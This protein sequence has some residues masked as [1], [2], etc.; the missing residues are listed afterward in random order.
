MEILWKM[1]MV[2]EPC[3]YD[4]GG[5][6][7]MQ[8]LWRQC[9]RPPR[10][11]VRVHHGRGDPCVPTTWLFAACSA[12][13]WVCVGT[14]TVPH[15]SYVA[16]VFE[17]RQTWSPPDLPTLNGDPSLHPHGSCY[18]VSQGWIE[19][20]SVDELFETARHYP[21]MLVFD[22]ISNACHARSIGV[23]FFVEGKF[24]LFGEATHIHDILVFNDWQSTLIGLPISFG[25]L[26]FSAP[27]SEDMQA[28]SDVSNVS[29]FS[30]LH[31]LPPP[32]LVIH[33]AAFTW[34]WPL[35]TSILP[36][37]SSLVAALEPTSVL[38]LAGFFSCKCKHTHSTINGAGTGVRAA[39]VRPQSEVQEQGDRGGVR[40]KECE[41]DC[42]IQLTIDGGNAWHGACYTTCFQK[43][44]PH[45]TVHQFQLKL[46]DCVFR[47]TP[48]PP[49]SLAP[50][51]QPGGGGQGEGED[52][53][54]MHLGVGVH[55]LS[56][57]L[58]N[59]D[60]VEI[61][62]RASVSVCVGACHA[63]WN[64]S[65]LHSPQEKPPSTPNSHAA[66][67]L[68]HSAP[69]AP[70]AAALLKDTLMRYS[71]AH[72]RS[73]HSTRWCEPQESV[74]MWRTGQCLRAL[75]YSC[76]AVMQGSVMCNIVM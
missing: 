1:R 30:F 29:A 11:S 23:Y 66:P 5:R 19:A 67:S 65:H 21:L 32:S 15:S 3:S 57:G 10:A 76:P 13:M 18:H 38:D 40:D 8:R 48:P 24:S 2:A 27:G 71:K 28:L 75:V 55:H 60:G 6:R 63:A 64:A 42:S 16:K 37:G 9:D 35:D 12:L 36:A 25:I 69:S 59:R 14:G 52:E 62:A 51:P 46:P 22:N 33:E 39:D 49:L 41:V 68:T 54:S 56:V 74:E 58:C 47:C 73:R 31:H 61:S 17:E 53:A 43:H 26:P 45:L 34:S 44:V 50:Q 72:A 70:S 4:D 7:R 20:I